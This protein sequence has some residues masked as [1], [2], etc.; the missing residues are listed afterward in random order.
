[1]RVADRSCR[2]RRQT[3]HRRQAE[4]LPKILESPCTCEDLLLRLT[5]L[6][7]KPKARYLRRL[8]KLCSNN[9]RTCCQNSENPVPAKK[10]Q[11]LLPTPS[12]AA[13]KI[14]QTQYLR[15][16]PKCAA[17]I[18]RS[19]CKN[20]CGPSTCEDS[21]SLPPRQA[22]QTREVTSPSREEVSNCH[23]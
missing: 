12:G 13:A 17:D 7:S 11:K 19:C 1:M 9:K 3:K 20:F 4:L 10:Y 22:E 8:S 18:K 14:L 2:C 23:C 16:I 21:Q 5:E 6:L 15:R